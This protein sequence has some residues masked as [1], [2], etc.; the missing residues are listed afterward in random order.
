MKTPLISVIIPTYNGYWLLEK[1]LRQICSVIEDEKVN[2]EILVIDDGSSDGTAD[3]FVDLNTFAKLIRRESQ[4][5]FTVACNHGAS[6]A[7]GKYIFFL[8]ND[9]TI[10]PEFFGRLLPYFDDDHVFAVT[11]RSYVSGGRMDEN[12]VLP[13]WE[14]GW[15]TIKTYND[16]MPDQIGRKHVFHASGGCCLIDKSKFMALG[17]FD[18]LY[19]PFYYEDV[20]LS[21]RAK[22]AGWLVIHDKRAVIHHQGSKTVSSLY[23]QT[24][25]N[26][27]YWRNHILFLWKNI[28]EPALRES[29]FNNYYKNMYILSL[30]QFP[31]MNAHK[32]ALSRLHILSKSY[33]ALQTPQVVSDSD[34]LLLSKSVSANND[35]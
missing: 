21:W 27:V 15:L 11:P 26:V 7:L 24:H 8:N 32:E 5:G 14:N 22:K 18:E 23:S 28:R 3:K 17:G 13:H 16:I 31:V 10:E 30:R 33:L 20:D 2:T 29:F 4:G 9:M 6:Y 12:A 25:K 34:L 1:N 19:S 35:L